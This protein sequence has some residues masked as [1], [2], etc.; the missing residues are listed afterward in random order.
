MVHVARLISRSDSVKSGLAGASRYVAR[1][2][3]GRLTCDSASPITGNCAG[4]LAMV[5]YFDGASAT[6]PPPGTCT[7][8]SSMNPIFSVRSSNRDGTT[9]G[10][11]PASSARS[12]L[13]ADWCDDRTAANVATASTNVPP[14]VASEETVAQ[15][16]TRR[17]YKARATACGGETS[18]R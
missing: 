18:R 15:S 17:D 2:A 4:G 16:A 3:L 7:Q 13:R 12:V 6:A 5:S 11:M 10:R 1:D 9:T 14:A 8:C